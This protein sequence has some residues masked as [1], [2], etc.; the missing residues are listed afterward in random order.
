MDAPET[1]LE[2]VR[3]HVRQGKTH[4]ASQCA[5]IA[6]LKALHLPTEVAEALL[7]C[8]EDSQRQHLAHLAR[9]EDKPE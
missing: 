8:F 7:D 1:E 5:I 2:M 3:R 4:L 6:R 9:I